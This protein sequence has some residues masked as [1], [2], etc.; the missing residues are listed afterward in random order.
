MKVLTGIIP[1]NA[2]IAAAYKNGS[3]YDQKFIQL[4]ALFLTSFF[5]KHLKLVETDQLKELVLLGHS[6]LVEISKV[7]ETELF[8]TCLEYWNWLAQSLVIS[9]QEMKVQGSMFAAP[10]MLQ[11]DDP[12]KRVYAPILSRVR[13]VMISK[14]A[15]PEE[16][17]I[18]EDENGQ[19]VKEYMKDV[20]TIQLYK[21]MKETLVFLTN[22]DPEDTE[23]IMLGKLQKQVDGSEWSYQNLNTLCWAVG[24]ISGA[25]DVKDEKRFLVTVIKDLLGLCEM[26]KGKPN[27][28]VVASN[29][30][31]VVG[32]Y[33]RFLVQHWKFLKTVV[34][35]LF[36]FMHEDFPGVQEMACET[37]VKIAKKCKRK[38]VIIHQGE[39]KPFID[40]IL[41]DLP[42][43]IS[44]LEP[45]HVHIFY[46]AVGYMISV[47]DNELMER[48][49]KKLMY[50]PNERWRAI[51]QG[52]AQNFESLKT[53]DT[54]TTLINL[55]KTNVA[56][57]KS[58][59]AAFILQMKDI[60]RDMMELYKAYSQMISAEVQKM[61]PL[62]TRHIH[63]KQMRS[64]KKEILALV[65]M[66]I[67]NSKDMQL[68]A[69]HFVPSLLEATLGDYKNS[70]P[71]A[72]DPGVL[73]LLTV[74][75]SQLKD[76]MMNDLPKIMESVLE[77]TLP[78][79]TKNLQD[80]TEHR[81]NLFNLLRAI[82][83]NCFAAFFKIP[84]QGFKLIIDSILW[85]SKHDHRSVYE[86]GLKILLEMLQNIENQNNPQLTSSFYQTFFI[87]ILNDVLFVLTDTLHTSSFK[88]QL[89][90]LHIMFRAVKEGKVAGP[91]YDP[92]KIQA[93][94][95]NMDYVKEYMTKLLCSSFPNLQPSIVQNFV[96]GLFNQ[97]NDLQGFKNQLRD[98]LVQI[99]EWTPEEQNNLFF[100][101]Q[102][103]QKEMEKK[104]MAMVPGLQQPE[105]LDD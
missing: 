32:Q 28:A 45:Q 51:I 80:Y 75:I 42:S 104:K 86:T 41:D 47:A 57:A 11:Q 74:V 99:K 39:T 29:I 96:I 8:K 43:I 62:V 101:Q 64:I 35:K 58:I 15:K 22:L 87:P 25:M 68:I 105:F 10:L 6:Y 30:M 63:V 3:D 76:T 50:S 97:T 1:P 61:G 54:M 48:L 83:S 67:K 5:K 102:K 84:P 66:F 38:F 40:E 4:L 18:V 85:A 59:G 71:D 27:K 19:I 89:E 103:M 44:D 37:Y 16:V 91:L 52:A 34:K 98:F 88:T 92:A 72:R 33:P 100:E 55:L 2:N 56:A 95:S 73:S 81:I 9:N 94:I 82:T 31:Y 17:I 7:D 23:N 69:K 21:S 13:T 77:C 36:E 26:T 65:E 12:R 20:D 49:I 78:M 14:M 90:I 53:H 60:F 79:I 46:E 70:V 93:P 24:S